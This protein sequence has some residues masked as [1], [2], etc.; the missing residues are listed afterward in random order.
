MTDESEFT[1]R[2]DRIDATLKESGWNV[3]NASHLLIELDTLQ[4]DFKIRRYMKISDTLK[5]QLESKYADY[6]LLDS[7]GD[8]IAII[9]AKRTSKDAILGRKQAELYASDIKRQ[10]S[11]DVFIYYT[12]G[13]EIWFWNKGHETPRQIK[14][15]HSREDLEK[16]RFQNGSKKRFSDIQIDRQITDRTYQIE[17]VKRV[18]EGIDDGKRKFLIVQAT[19]TGKTRVSMSLI[20]VLL[21]SRRIERVLFLTD[22][23]TLR[24]QAY[25]DGFKVFFTSEAKA[26]VVGKNTLLLEEKEDNI[27]ISS[28]GTTKGRVVPLQGTDLQNYRLYASTIQT[29]SECYRDFSIGFFDVIISDEA[30]RSI[31]NKWRD[32]FTYF[33]CIQIGLTATPAQ[34]IERDT[35]RFFD[36]Q[37]GKPTAL[38]TYEQA[39]QDGVLVD[40]KVHEAQTH[41]QIEGVRWKDIPPDVREELYSSD[42]TTDDED[43]VFDG[44]DIEKKVIITGT[45]EKIIKEFYEYSLKDQAGNLP[46][47]TIIFA[48]SQNHAKR[49]IEIFDRLYPK[50]KGEMAAIIISGDSRA[51]FSLRE[52]K[53][54]DRPR[55]AISVDMLDT[56][57]DIPEVCNLV[58]AKPVFSNIRFWQMIGRGTRS[59][60]TCKHHEWLPNGRKTEFLIFDFWKN[61]EFFDM[62]PEGKIVSSTEAL[63]TKI[64][65]TRLATYDFLKRAGDEENAKTVLDKLTKS[66]NELPF[67]SI[68]VKDHIR[69]IEIV[70]KGKLFETVSIQDEV[71]FLR[72]KIAPLLKYTSEV[73]LQRESFRLKTEQLGLAILTGDREEIDRNSQDIGDYLIRLPRS[74][75]A[76][77][78]KEQLIDTILTKRFW[79]SIRYDQAMMIQDELTDIMDNLRPEPIVRIN[80][81]LDDFI[82]QRRTILYGFPAKEE[83]IEVYRE[84]IER[85]IRQL[86]LDN[87]VITKLKINEPLTVIDIQDLEQ[88]LNS[89]DL[90]ITEDNLQ[91]VYDRKASLVDF[92]KHIIGLSKLPS[93]EERISEAFKTFVVEKNYLNS[94]QVNFLRILETVFTQKKHIEMQDLYELPFTNLGTDVPVPL[95]K[96]EELTEMVNLCNR[97]QKEVY[98]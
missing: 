50:H 94:N 36:C 73:N 84:K 15:F 8:P 43:K 49:L 70:T 68:S 96:E 76:V 33:D 42:S 16:L 52:F 93:A 59:N 47:K 87:K 66:V 38:Y 48:V 60:D 39:V 27:R 79:Q 56:G 95:F 30:H 41:F 46:A 89:P 75:K 88:K 4:S 23:I 91:K 35:F 31:Y 86:A 57:V 51:Q 74:I 85:K 40:F 26:K 67:D 2:R 29:F 55:I 83:Y 18:L 82:Q 71:E 53:R 61:F 22:R 37:D 12:N 20:D 54:E 98:N 7:I 72:K 34:F 19:G 10:T 44:T 17:S 92:I 80:L 3:Q 1:T 21:K 25:D 45:N 97:L 58:F 90:F 13:Y 65:L 14:G 11:K 5:N 81:D 9:E 6:V 32:V 63:P 62:H 64:F 24:D 28:L 69:E 78:D 77:K